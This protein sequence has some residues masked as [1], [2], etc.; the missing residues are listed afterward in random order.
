[1]WPVTHGRMHGCTSC[2][3]LH[4]RI[5]RIRPAANSMC[6]Q[7]SASN[8]PEGSVVPRAQ[9]RSRTAPQTD[10]AWTQTPGPRPPQP[11]ASRAGA[12]GPAAG[13]SAPSPSCGAPPRRRRRR[14]RLRWCWPPPEGQAAGTGGSTRACAHAQRH[15]ARRQSQPWQQHGGRRQLAKPKPNAA[16]FGVEGCLWQFGWRHQ[17]LLVQRQPLTRGSSLGGCVCGRG[18]RVR[19]DGARGASH[20]P[21]PRLASRAE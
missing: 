7:G 11:G 21:R 4:A 5:Y 20:L 8:C 12:R 17:H 1:M 13:R 15:P 10:P 2:M 14:L 9:G 19:T 6:A 3:V 16:L 18:R